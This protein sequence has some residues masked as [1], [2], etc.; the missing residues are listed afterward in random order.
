MSA[1]KSEVISIR[2]ERHIKTAL[3]SAAERE[4]R[5]LANMIEVMVVAYCQAKGFPVD[6]VSQATLAH[7]QLRAD[8]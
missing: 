2:V 7:I 4:M 5:S 8:A 3:K 6:D 1:G